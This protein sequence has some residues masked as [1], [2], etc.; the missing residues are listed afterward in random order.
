MRWKLKWMRNTKRETAQ[1]ALTSTKRKTNRVQETVISKNLR[2]LKTS[3][4][5]KEKILGKKLSAHSKCGTW[6][7]GREN[8][9]K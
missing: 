2:I 3:M 1:K 8:L 9:M 6:S 7:A 5:R 4:L